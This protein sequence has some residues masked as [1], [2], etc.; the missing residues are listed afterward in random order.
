MTT[1]NDM[2]FELGGLP[3]LPI[4]P[5]APGG[6]WYWVDP[7]NGSASN[8][9][10]APVPDNAGHGPLATVGAAYARC[11]TDHH[12]VVAL[13]EADAASVESTAMTWSKDYTHLVGFWSPVREGQRARITQLSTLTGASPF[14]TISGSGCVFA[15]VRIW[16]GVN[17]ATSLINVSVTGQRNTFY[18]VNFAGG[19][20]V[21]QAIDGGA[22]LHL[23]GGSENLFDR[24]TIGIDT[25][26]Q[27][28]GMA[29]LV[30]A[31]TGGAARNV[32]RDCLFLAYAA[33]TTPAGVIFVELLGNAGIDRYQLF[34]RCTFANLASAAMTSA[35][36][37]AAGFDPANKRVLLRDCALIGAGDWD[38]NNRGILYL[39][40]G[41]ITGGGNAGLFAVSSST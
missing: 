22:S 40:N 2:L 30:F 37:I 3:A 8:D 24:C 28:T 6:T 38:S 20:H 5:I 17:D 39:N 13:M 25:V 32:F 15:N 35:F 16:Q 27:S 4:L 23:S 7:A 11:T 12:D 41:A 18:N 21:A 14:L 34:D 19:G 36:A 9:G 29:A 31:A 10:L 33:G 26:A 1:L